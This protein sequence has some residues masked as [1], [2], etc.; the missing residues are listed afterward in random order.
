MFT[1][2]LVSV[3][4]GGEICSSGGGVEGSFLINSNDELLYNMQLFRDFTRSK[5]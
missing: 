4:V 5:D 2:I 3:L 1:S